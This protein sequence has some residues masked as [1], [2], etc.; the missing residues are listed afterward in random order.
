MVE[1]IGHGM[2]PVFVEDLVFRFAAKLEFGELTQKVANTAVR[3]V[4]RMDKD[5][6]TMG[7]RPARIDLLH[8]Q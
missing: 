5:W 6:M 2:E 4:R 3:L 8:N 1:V 7:C